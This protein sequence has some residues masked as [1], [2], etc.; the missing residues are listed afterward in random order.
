M[1][2]YGGLIVDKKLLFVYGTLKRGFIL[3]PYLNE[4]KYLGE[5]EVYGFTLY[6]IEPKGSFS[7]PYIAQA[8]KENKVKGELWEIDDFD[9]EVMKNMELKAGFIHYYYKSDKGNINL[10]GMEKIWKN[11]K[12]IGEE[13]L[14]Q[15][16]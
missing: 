16:Q 5:T 13:F 11:T 8:P 1:V 15:M 7:Y 9:F 12:Y 4:A 10:F 14:K 2:L 3:N 6:L